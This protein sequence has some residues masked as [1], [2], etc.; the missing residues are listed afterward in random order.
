[1][2]IIPVIDLKHGQV[3]HAK[4][5]DRDNY[6]PIC[7]QL[8]KKSDIFS[9]IDAFLSLYPFDLFYIA[10]LDA[11]TGIG[12]HDELLHK[13]F[14]HF[15]HIT[16]WLDN[17]CQINEKRII[18]N[19]WIPVIGSESIQN[20]HLTDLKNNQNEFI[21][22]LDHGKFGRLGANRLFSE[23][24]FWPSNVIIMTLNSVGSGKGPDMDKL[25]QFRQF[26][27]EQCFIAA[28]GV[29]NF[30]DCLSL[31]QIGINQTLVASAL[32]SGSL[33]A[34]DITNLQTKKYPV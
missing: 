31:K 16:F 22:S 30:E 20:N 27:P 4:Q 28:G 7:T 23:P 26:Q 18:A 21:L 34:A 10:D 1:M 2:K 32:H 25:K 6:Q 5:G 24:I 19:N 14:T 13:I 29:R 11:I 12:Q 17:G 3:V 9:V 15:T 33:T 8:S